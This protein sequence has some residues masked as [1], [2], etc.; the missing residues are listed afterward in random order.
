MAKTFDD[1][2]YSLCKN[3]TDQSQLGFKSV[4]QTATGFEIEYV[5]G[6]KATYT[7]QNMH[8]HTNMAILNVLNKDADGDLT[9]NG[10][11]ITNLTNDQE[12]LLMKFSL[13]AD[14]KLLFDGKEITPDFIV[15]TGAGKKFLADDGTYKT[16]S[17]GAPY[18]DT[19]VRALIDTN[20]T[21]ITDLTTK[22]GTTAMGTT[23]TDVTGAVA[24]VN[25]NQLD[26]VSF[27]ADYKNIVLNRK[28]GTN[29]YA[30]PIAAI[31]NHAKLIELADIDTADIGNG[32]TLVYDAVTQKHK[33]VSSSGTDELVKMDAASDAHYLVDLIDKQTVVNDNGILKV[34]KLDGQEVTITE[35]NYLKGLTMNVMDLVNA[36]A[37]GGVKVLNTPVA[38][39]ADLSTLDRST[40][41]DGISYIV[42]VLADESHAGAKTTY[43]C[44]KTSSTYFGNA[45]SQRNFTT[46]PIDLASEVTGK[47]GTSNIDVDS[48]WALLTIDDTYKTLTATDNVFGTHGAKAMYDE[49]VTAIG[50]KAN[51]VG[52]T[53]HTDDTDIHITTTERTKWNEVVNKANKTEVLLQDKIQ[54]TSGNE[55][56]DNVYSAQLTK[57]ELDKKANDS[58][59]VKKTDIA[60]SISSTSTNDKVAGA[61]AVHD[62]L[63]N[64][65]DK[66]VILTTA[67]EV[68]SFDR[69]Y[70]SFI[71]EPSVAEA[72]GLPKA[73]ESTW[74]CINLSHFKGF[75]YPSQIAFE[76]AGIE[77]IMYR[78]AHNGVW[79]NW[80]KIP[81]TSV[82]DVPFT[83]LTLDSS[84]F[85]TSNVNNYIS[86]IVCN[87]MCTIACK[88]IGLVSTGIYDIASD[89]PKPVGGYATNI[90]QVKSGD[91]VPTKPVFLTID[92]STLKLFSESSTGPFWGTVT[93]PVA[94]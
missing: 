27:S 89:I 4:K 12:E 5:N 90:L 59:V 36:F 41:I 2:V 87:G 60:T 91:I 45:D 66:T 56:H 31:I 43:L 79:H 38:T 26:T 35:I 25:G 22:I 82:A 39:Y 62:S 18:D 69:E 55:T 52:L 46:D 21:D 76:Y 44:D 10:E 61:K 37:N 16:I 81:N 3:Y 30:I 20:K 50:T 34:K 58:E 28:N 32:K 11:K 71:I 72:V 78:T 19:E 13:S 92:N 9:F 57:T 1:V 63:A 93:Y 6:T 68:N 14:N 53:A 7:V 86:Y 88:G 77:R 70:Q 84:V 47:L 48:L 24:E 15:T 23:A 94:E 51:A 42:Y 17:G 64:K 67:D 73:P 74:F 29:P 85:T 33:Y 65:L 40:F 75:K 83:K 49:L 54:T 80:R 8:K